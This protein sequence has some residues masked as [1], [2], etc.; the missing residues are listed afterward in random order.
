MHVIKYNQIFEFI[1]HEKSRLNL[2]NPALVYR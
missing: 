2:I 1:A